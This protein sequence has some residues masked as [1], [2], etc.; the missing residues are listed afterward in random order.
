M[1]PFDKRGQ[2]EQAF[3]LA[4]DGAEIAPE[5]HLW[6]KIDASLSRDQ[7]GNYKKRLFLFQLVAAASLVF[8]AT[9]TLFQVF[10]SD[11]GSTSSDQV[12]TDQPE[13]SKLTPIL[14]DAENQ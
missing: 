2:F 7:S 6:D 9:I 12:L 13:G 8:A 10:I 1:D 3:S 14:Q 4:F 5:P 11:N